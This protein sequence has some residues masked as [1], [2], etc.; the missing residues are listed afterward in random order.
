MIPNK[1]VYDTSDN[2]TPQKLI[3][4]REILLFVF[5]EP[6]S[7]NLSGKCY[8]FTLTSADIVYNIETHVH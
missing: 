2:R 7:I 1:D 5:N 8:G 3:L 6:I 4:Q